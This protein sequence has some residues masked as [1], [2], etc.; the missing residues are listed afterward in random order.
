M[1]L[2]AAVIILVLIVLTWIWITPARISST[3]DDNSNALPTML[4]QRPTPIN[5]ITFPR[6]NLILAYQESLVAE[7]TWRQY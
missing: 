4:L 5:D 2:A 6:Q 7:A 3:E 1:L